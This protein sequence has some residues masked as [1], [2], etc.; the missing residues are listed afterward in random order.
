MMEDEADVLSNLCVDLVSLRRLE[1]GLDHLFRRQAPGRWVAVSELYEKA[2]QPDQAI[3][4]QLAAAWLPSP[5][6]PDYAVI[7]FFDDTTK[8]SLTA[9][10]NVAR[11]LGQQPQSQVAAAG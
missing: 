4:P 6:D 10:Y 8:W 1:P 2:G 5:G 11:L 9:D 7:L 3:K